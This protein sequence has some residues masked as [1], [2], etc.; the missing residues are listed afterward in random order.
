MLNLVYAAKKL[1]LQAEGRKGNYETLLNEKMPCIAHVTFD[2]RLM[3]Y[4]IIYQITGT[5]LLLGDP[6]KGLY[7]SSKK[8]F[9]NIWNSNAVILLNPQKNL[10]NK[11][12][13]HWIQWLFSYFMKESLWINQSVFLESS[14]R[15]LV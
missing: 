1:G 5:Y 11:L 6:G 3:H 8:D 9:E 7:K 15:F 4:L 14:I 12:Q 10:Y 2:K 13:K